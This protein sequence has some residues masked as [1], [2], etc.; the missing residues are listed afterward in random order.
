[1]KKMRVTAAIAVPMVMVCMGVRSG[2]INVIEGSIKGFL[3]RDR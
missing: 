3:C 1:M 2:V